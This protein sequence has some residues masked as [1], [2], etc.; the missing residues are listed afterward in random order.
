MALKQ[1]DRPDQAACR[2]GKSVDCARVASPAASRNLQ[3]KLQANHPKKTLVP[4][5][6]NNISVVKIKGNHSEHRGQVL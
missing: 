6:A 2:V 3:K 5:E 4:S 1:V